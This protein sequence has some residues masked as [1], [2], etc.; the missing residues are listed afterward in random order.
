MPDELEPEAR[1][2]RI[3]RTAL[4][5]SYEEARDSIANGFPVAVCSSQGFALTRDGDGFAQPTGTWFH[6]MKFIA[7]KDD[8]R[9][10]LLCMNSWGED[11]PSGPKGKYDIPNGSFWVDAVTCTQ[12]FSEW[13][14][15]FAISQFDGYPRRVEGLAALTRSG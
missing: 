5:Q 10:G 6:C 12:M 3:R 8:E 13:R 9:P 14:D 1:E 7:T 4:V 2:H 11:K 15:S